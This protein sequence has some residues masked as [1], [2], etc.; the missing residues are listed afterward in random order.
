MLFCVS[1]N[2]LLVTVYCLLK[3]NY[4]GKYFSVTDGVCLGGGPMPCHATRTIQ[5]WT[6]GVCLFT[7]LSIHI[8]VYLFSSLCVIS[9]IGIVPLVSLCSTCQREKSRP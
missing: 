2:I 5:D 6:P 1:E 3:K 7:S 9:R 4:D 8:F